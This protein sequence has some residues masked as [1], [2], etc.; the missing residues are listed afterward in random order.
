MKA[1]KVKRGT[2]IKAM[3]LASIIGLTVPLSVVSFTLMA[4]L[5]F[6]SFNIFLRALLMIVFGLIG[7]GAGSIAYLRILNRVRPLDLLKGRKNKSYGS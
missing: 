6:E 5:I 2:I 1:D 7:L 4:L 3:I